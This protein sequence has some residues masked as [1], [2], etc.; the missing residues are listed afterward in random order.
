[1][2]R[3]S[4]ASWT[5]HM[6]SI[7]IFGTLWGI[8]F[9]EWQGASASVRRLIAVGIALLI[10]STI[11]VGVGTWMRSRTSTTSEPL[12]VAV[13]LSPPSYAH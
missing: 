10:T 13:S 5:L 6:A 4:F 8:Y 11:V 7:M 3:F 2:G 9:R 1:M 12:A